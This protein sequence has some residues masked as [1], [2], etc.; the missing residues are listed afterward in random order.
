MKIENFRENGKKNYKICT[1]LIGKTFS[2]LSICNG[3]Y[4]TQSKV[5]LFS[6]KLH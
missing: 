4:L 6:I 3:S 1:S 5:F 2:P